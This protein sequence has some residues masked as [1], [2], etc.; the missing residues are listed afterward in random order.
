MRV[1][2]LSTMVTVSEKKWLSLKRYKLEKDSEG[3]SFGVFY[4]EEISVG[5]E[6]Y[7]IEMG[8]R[9]YF[10]NLSYISEFWAIILKSRLYFSNLSYK[11]QI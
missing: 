6:I 1:M 4:Y 5:A 7:D 9:L 11:S 3:M 10:W 8:F 2:D